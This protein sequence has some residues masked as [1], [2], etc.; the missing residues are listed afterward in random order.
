M[1]TADDVM[2]AWEVLESTGMRRPW[3]AVD[4]CN[5]AAAVWAAVLADVPGEQLAALVVAWLRSPESRF[6]RWPLPGALLAAIP[7]DDGVDD[8]DDAWAEALGLIRMLGVERCPDTVEDLEDLRTRL[9]AGYRE[10]SAKGDEGR[11]QRYK[12]LGRALPSEDEQRTHALL[13]G[14][15]ACGGWR[16]LG[17]ATDDRMVAHRASFRASYRGHQQRRR[18]TATERQVAALLDGNHGPGLRLVGPA[19][20]GA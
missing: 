7:D 2:A 20:G 4:D 11:M 8:A 19:E 18:L 6:G 5:R 3:D 9:R 16:G 12:R 10:A 13:A 17:R 14:V 1:A 15:R